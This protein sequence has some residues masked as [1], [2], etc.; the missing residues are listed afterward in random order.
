MPRGWRRGAA[1]SE[2]DPMWR[3]VGTCQAVVGFNGS[4]KALFVL[5]GNAAQN[6]LL[7]ALKSTGEPEQDGKYEI[8]FRKLEEGTV[9]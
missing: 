2:N 4:F 9:E 7:D 8:T 1:R 6:I 3:Y 5:D